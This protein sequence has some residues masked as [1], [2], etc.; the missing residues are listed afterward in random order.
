MQDFHLSAPAPSV[1]D[2]PVIETP[3]LRLRAHRESDLEPYFA[4]HA[5]PA[6]MRYWS[7]PAWTSIDQAR[8]RLA[9]VI[10]H[11]D[12]GQALCWAVADR[13]DDRL[14]GS[15]VLFAINREQGRAE[16]GYALSSGH[17][18]RGLAQEA[19]A[20]V[21]EH[22]FDVLGLRRIE[23]DIDPRNAGS[24]RLV[25]RMGFIREGLLRDRWCV[26]GE[27]SDS[28]IYGLLAADWRAR[29]R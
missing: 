21:L 17:W 3:R 4:L 13:G 24:C 15:I 11:R 2:L 23:A 9:E 25:E 29:G 10:G 19:M 20:P 12:A 18:G 27:V 14:I 8:D 28:A 22:A 1:D 26:G 6:V 16:T 5:D 7:C